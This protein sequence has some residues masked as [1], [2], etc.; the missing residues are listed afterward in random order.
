ML[1]F[2]ISNK[3]NSLKQLEGFMGSKIKESDNLL[4]KLTSIKEETNIHYC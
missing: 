3:L 4:L 2:D 1:N